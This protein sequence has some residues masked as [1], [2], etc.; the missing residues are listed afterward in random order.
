MAFEQLMAEA[1]MKKDKKDEKKAKKESKKP[2]AEAAPAGAD[3]G[4][5]KYDT[6]FSDDGWSKEKQ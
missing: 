1:Q 2:A 5:Y 6:K 3:S 4:H